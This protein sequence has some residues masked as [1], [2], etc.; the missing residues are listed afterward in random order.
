MNKSRNENNFTFSTR[1][2][3]KPAFSRVKSTKKKSP[4]GPKIH[5]KVGSLPIH[6]K[7]A[8]LS[9]DKSDLNTSGK[10]KSQM[11]FR[12]VTGI[13]PNQKFVLETPRILTYTYETG[14]SL[15]QKSLLKSVSQHGNNE[16]I[17]SEIN[18]INGEKNEIHVKTMSRFGMHNDVVKALSLG[19]G[20]STPNHV[21]SL[22]IPVLMN[23]LQ[24]VF[25]GAETGSMYL[26]FNLNNI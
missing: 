19:L 8:P 23:P 5:P 3:R 26:L 24:D 17:N 25:L 21:Q 9:P 22:A 20:I 14:H 12:P 4:L 7:L 10:L 2:P 18:E 11:P 1:F 13:D 16:N 15:S 6:L